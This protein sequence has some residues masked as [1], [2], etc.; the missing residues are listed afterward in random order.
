[1]AT[2]IEQRLVALLNGHDYALRLKLKDYPEPESW[3]HYIIAPVPGYLEINGPWPV[4]HV[5]WVEV[6][7]VVTTSRGRLIPP[8]VDDYTGLLTRQLAQAGLSFII[9]DDGYI[10]IFLLR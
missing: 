3:G 1:M 8:Q 2:P 5:E 9:T 4:R 6:N 7:P 10:R